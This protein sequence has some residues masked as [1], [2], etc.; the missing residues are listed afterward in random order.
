MKRIIL[1]VLL[2]TASFMVVAQ[3]FRGMKFGDE[4]TKIH[5]QEINVGSKRIQTDYV[6]IHIY[7][8]VYL[9]RVA[10]ILFSCREGEFV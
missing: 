4:C 9:D 5:D 3:D 6:D 10:G 7:E 1:F 8:D 2:A